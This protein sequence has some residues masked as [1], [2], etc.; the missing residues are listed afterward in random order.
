MADELH[1]L[2]FVCNSVYHPAESCQH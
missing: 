2:A 1:A